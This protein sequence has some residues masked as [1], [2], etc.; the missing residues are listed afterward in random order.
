MNIALQNQWLTENSVLYA[1]LTDT[2]TSLKRQEEE[3]LRHG[4]LTKSNQKPHP[5]GM[6][7]NPLVIKWSCLIASKC[8]KRGYDVVRSIL[9]IP[10]W[11]T[12][13]QYRQAAST[14]SPI[15]HQ[16]L[17]HM[18]QE[19]T[20]RGCKGVGRIHWDEMS[21]KEGIVPCK[22]TG[23]LVGFEDLNINSELNLSPHDLEN[24]DDNDE[25]TSESS[26]SDTGPT[27]SD[28]DSDG[29]FSNEKPTNRSK[30]AKLICQFFYSSIEGDFSWPVASF[31]LQKIDHRALSS[32]VWQVFE[33]IGSL[34]LENGKKI[35]VIYGVSD[36]STYSHAFFSRAGAQNWVTYNPFNDNEPI[37]WLSDYP[38]M[39]KKLRNFIVNPDG[40]LEKEGR[41]ITADH[42]IPVVKRQLTK[43]N[44]KHLKLT[45]RTKMS[46]KRAVTL[47]SVDVALDILKGPLPPEETVAT[48]SYINQ[49]YKLFKI[50]NNNLEVDPKCYKE[51]LKILLWFDNWYKE[52]KQESSKATSGLKNHWKNFIPRITFKDLKRSIRA[53]LGVVQYVQ[54]H[55]PEL[56]IIPKTMCQDDVENYFSQ[57]N[58]QECQEE[59]QQHYIFLSHLLLW[60]LNY[61]YLLK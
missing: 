24:E 16:N 38:H 6:S 13:K 9:P 48:R 32:L 60:K 14:T 35:E 58:V 43:L 18:L 22:R 4:N 12:I 21:V 59:N 50:F 52:T 30:K 20:R 49:C 41:K 26:D 54:M 29:I 25:N 23:E 17:A 27:D 56:H 42:L 10:T 57:C 36:G 33:A 34:N 44:W 28:S 37:W 5:K 61:F 31:P 3:F 1:L 51:L 40:Q 46:V 2:L 47:C 39:I 53:F 45:P 15:S 8:Y 7:Y 55:H 19:M 11:E